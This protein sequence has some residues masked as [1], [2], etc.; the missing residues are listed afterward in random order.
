[1]KPIEISQHL[2]QLA[3]NYKI[4][5]HNMNYTTMDLKHIPLNHLFAI[6]CVTSILKYKYGEEALRPNL[7]N[8][9]C[10]FLLKNYGKLLSNSAYKQLLNKDS[11]KLYEGYY[12]LDKNNTSEYIDNLFEI[13]Y[14]LYEV[15][16]KNRKLGDIY[17]YKI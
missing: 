14:Y 11:L 17:D 5:I 1:M 4:T 16:Y 8:E 13:S 2:K 9:L 7:Y 6:Y 3:L 10:D 15:Y 12:I